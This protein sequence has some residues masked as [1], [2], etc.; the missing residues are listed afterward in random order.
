MPAINVQRSIQINSSIDHVTSI[1]KDF[2]QWRAWSP[3]LITEPEAQMII[4]EDGQSYTWQGDR[5]GQGSM[6]RLATSSDVELH[7]D[8]VFLKPW[9]SEAKVNFSLAQQ[10]NGVTVTWSMDSKLP[11]FMFWM[12]KM[13]QAL[14]GMDYERGLLMLKDYSE[15]DNVVCQLDI[16]GAGQ[17]A[18]ANFIGLKRQC[19]KQDIDTVME[20]DFTTL[21]A[22]AKNNPEIQVIKACSIYHQFDLVTGEVEYTAG[23][24]VEELPSS[25]TAPFFSGKIPSMKTFSLKQTGPYKHLGNGWSMIMGLKRAKAFKESKSHPPF[26]IYHNNPEEVPE[27]QLETEIV[28]AVK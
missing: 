17:F 19:I 14:I 26:E 27:N 1:L 25:L 21:M 5:V 20:E 6:T 23:L 24:I 7:F 8:L 3:W 16:L 15:Q 10:K 4:A 2:E 13:M 28:F 22:F 9:K 12:K 11:F 18:K